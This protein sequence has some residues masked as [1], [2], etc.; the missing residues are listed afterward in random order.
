M[1]FLTVKKTANM[2]RKYKVV[3]CRLAEW[4]RYFYV[5]V[6]DITLGLRDIFPIRIRIKAPLI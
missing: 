1:A 3:I 4:A 6:R 5:L 2:I